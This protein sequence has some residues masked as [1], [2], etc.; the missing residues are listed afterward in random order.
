MG[1][2]VTEK[3]T[4]S[5]TLVVNAVWYLVWNDYL[6]KGCILVGFDCVSVLWSNVDRPGIMPEWFWWLELL[7]RREVTCHVQPS[8]SPPVSQY[9]SSA[10]APRTTHTDRRAR[11]QRSSN[12]ALA[13]AVTAPHSAHRHGSLSLQLNL[14]CKTWKVGKK[15]F[16]PRRLPIFCHTCHNSLRKVLWLEQFIF[17]KY[18]NL[19]MKILDFARFLMKLKHGFLY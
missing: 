10:P 9:R 11:L 8:Q 12:G 2:W 18:R 4:T 1:G 17:L 6:S 14:T 13:R 7:A 19:K 16:L 3:L 5:K 15:V